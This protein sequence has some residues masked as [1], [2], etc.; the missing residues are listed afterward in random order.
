MFKEA[1]NQMQQPVII[2]TE[3]YIISYVNDAYEE[4]FELKSEDIVG[5]HLH[6]VFTD[7]PQENQVVTEMIDNDIRKFSKKVTHKLGGEILFLDSV[8]KRFEYEGEK[9]V[10]TRFEDLTEHA[11]QEKELKKMIIDMTVNVVPLSDTI[12]VLPLPP[13]LRDEQK[14]VIVEKTAQICREKRFSKLAIN[15]S[16][17]RTLDEELGDIIIRLIEVLRV[18]GVD[19]ILTGVRHEIAA[20][21]SQVDLDFDRI[22]VYQNLKQAVEYFFSEPRDK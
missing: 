16:A 8:S 22:K 21:F 17:I 19:V 1:L 10:M 6:D 11:R 5:K 3:D 12:G 20:D 2:N 9:Y 7:T 13:I 14:W 18:L 4:L 15:L